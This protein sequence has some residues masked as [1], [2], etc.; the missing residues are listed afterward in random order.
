MDTNSLETLK[1]KYNEDFNTALKMY[2]NNHSH[3]DLINFL[4]NGSI[5]EKQI[6]TLKLEKLDSQ[7][8]SHIFINNLTGCDGKIREA[9]SFRLPEFVKKNPS[10]FIEYTDIFLD[11][12]ID[13]NG[14][15][16]RNTICAINYLKNEKVFCR[17]FCK[18]LAK[19]TLKLAKYVKTFNLQ[20]GKYKVNKEVFKLYW[21]LETIYNF[22]DFMNNDDLVLIISETKDIIDY[23]I[24]EKTAKILS[25]TGED[26]F[27]LKIREKLRNDSNYYVRRF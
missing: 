20:D 24:R 13:I 8:D 5:V 18:K 4:K 3:Q 9:V 15:I 23:T 27:F 26:E 11:A 25:K 16:C 14:N 10:F 12:I 21:Y 2:E 6:A 22:F 7:E 17:D 1:K 19:Y